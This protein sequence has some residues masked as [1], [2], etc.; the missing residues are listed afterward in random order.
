MKSIK[1]W[2]K[3]KYPVKN[4]QVLDRK[5]LTKEIVEAIDRD[6]SYRREVLPSYLKLIEFNDMEIFGHCDLKQF[7]NLEEINNLCQK[8]EKLAKLELELEKIQEQ[9]LETNIE[10]N[11]K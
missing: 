10:Q 8:Q 9:K 6:K 5:Y 4:C 3:D 11:I 2:L 7:I 1:E